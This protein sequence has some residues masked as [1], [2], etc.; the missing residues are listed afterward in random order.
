MR[1]NLR[2]RVGQYRGSANRR[3]LIYNHLIFKHYLLIGVFRTW[4]LQAS[5]TR[6][7]MLWGNNLEISEALLISRG[8]MSFAS[9]D[10]FVYFSISDATETTESARSQAVLI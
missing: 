9:V 6:N 4:L 3:D 1:P 2:R 7:Y 8:K 10:R 5:L